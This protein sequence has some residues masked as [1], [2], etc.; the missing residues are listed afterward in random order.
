[1]VLEAQRID[2]N[3]LNFFIEKYVTKGMEIGQ[4]A[5]SHNTQMLTGSLKEN[6][7]QVLASK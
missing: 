7:N 2:N 1:M 5:F 6:S 4:L 3:L